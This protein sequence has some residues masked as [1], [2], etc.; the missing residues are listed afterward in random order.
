MNIEKGLI[1]MARSE[2]EKLLEQQGVL[3]VVISSIDGFD[4]AS[5]VN[6]NLEPA[7]IAAMTSSIAAIGVVVSQEA[8]LGV[9]KS[10]TVNT[11]DGFVYINNIDLA[12]NQCGLNVIA[13]NTA[14]L[15]QIIYHCGEVKKRLGA[16]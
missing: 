3:G 13:N 1:A 12:G 4:V 10:V 8:A 5:A 15:A 2:C 16:S 6:N 7:K 11:A 14:V 9:S